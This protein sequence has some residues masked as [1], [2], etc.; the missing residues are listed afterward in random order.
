MRQPRLRWQPRGVYG[1][2]SGPLWAAATQTR[3]A[4]HAGMGAPEAGRRA[5]QHIH[6]LHSLH[7]PPSA[8]CH[9]LNPPPSAC[10]AA[11]HRR[12]R[13]SA[14]PPPP[15]PPP[16]QPHRSP[17][18]SPTPAGPA[19][20]VGLRIEGREGVGAARSRAVPCTNTRHTRLTMLR[21]P[22]C[23]LGSVSQSHGWRSKDAPPTPEGPDSRDGRNSQT[24]R[25]TDSQRRGRR[26]NR[27]LSRAP[28]RT[29]HP[30]RWTRPGL[31][32]QAPPRPRQT[33]T[34]AYV[35]DVG[36]RCR[37]RQPSLVD[38]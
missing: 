34:P 6:S 5:E 13:P 10:C 28:K 26:R 31:V 25:L 9:S 38:H 27:P 4:R 37:P 11:H 14:A 29:S 22:W 32:A 1:S 20:C 18:H 16:L 12:H 24:D 21:A 35:A 8:C 15:P 36:A 2:L 17:A 30:R 7:P 3:R 33:P 23:S 19:M